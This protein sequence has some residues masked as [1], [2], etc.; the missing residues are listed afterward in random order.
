M[1]AKIKLSVGDKEYKP[2]DVIE[3][4][5]SKIDEAFLLKEG[6]IK[7]DKPSTA[8]NASSSSDTAKDDK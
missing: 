6:Y 1:I 2:G 5:M 3:K 7:N 4:K 8:K